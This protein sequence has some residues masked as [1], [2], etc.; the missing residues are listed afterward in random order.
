M[1]V[2]LRPWRAIEN[3][4]G[5]LV[6]VDIGVRERLFLGVPAVFFMVKDRK[7]KV[8]GGMLKRTSLLWYI[9]VLFVPGVAFANSHS[10]FNNTG[11]TI[12]WHRDRNKGFYL[13]LGNPRT[14]RHGSR[15][16]SVTGAGNLDCGGNL[17]ACKG[18]VAWRTPDTPG[19]TRSMINNVRTG[20]TNLGA[21]GRFTI[22]ERMANHGGVVFT[23]TFT[24][25]IWSYVGTCTGFP[26]CGVSGGYYAWELSGTVTGTITVNGQKSW[27]SGATVQFMTQR[28][29]RDPFL[30]GKGGICLKDGSTSLSGVAPEPG[31]LALFGGGIVVGLGLLA[32]NKYL[33]RLGT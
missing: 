5:L 23:G 15:L 28:F 26:A 11:G 22:F 10:S 1:S 7:K 4:F 17:R 25:A 9:A 3:L 33:A 16:T 2:A 30:R 21:G 27:I 32:K 18:G 6:P 20:S 13:Q 8:W 19:L 14:G 24:S 31:T 12:H 29:K